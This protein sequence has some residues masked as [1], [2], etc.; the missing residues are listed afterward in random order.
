MPS[1]ICN[2]PT[3]YPPEIIGYAHPWIASGGDNVEIKVSSTQSPYKYRLL[4]LIQGL[5]VPHSPEVVLEHIPQA[6]E[7]T[8]AGRYQQSNPGSYGI[9]SNL[10]ITNQDQGLA[11]SLYVQPTLVLAGHTQTIVSLIDIGARSGITVLIGS[12]GRLKVRVGNGLNLLEFLIGHNIL[13][14]KQWL[15]LRLTVNQS[16]LRVFLQ[17]VHHLD[18]T[19]G[20]DYDETFDIQGFEIPKPG[21]AT[22]AASQPSSN[23]KACDFFNGRIEALHL[24]TLGESP[25]VILDLD[26]KLKISTDEIVDVSRYGNHGVLINAPTRAVTGHDWDGSETDWSKASNGYGAIHFHEDDL[27]DAAW[28]TDFVLQVPAG[29]RSGA[30]AVE[31]VQLA[32]ESVKDY[33]TFFVRPNYN[34]STAK[35]A[36]VL[37]TFTYTAYANERMY[38][39]TKSS[40]LAASGCFKPRE[41]DEDFRRMKRRNDL[42]LS[43]YDVHR[44]GSG[45]VFSST[46]RP[47]LNVRPGFHHWALDRPRE[48]SADLLMIGFLEKLK[49]PYDVTTDHDLH[50]YGI[51]ALSPYSTIIT[52]S[53]PEYPS[54]ECL[55]TYSAFAARG[56][57]IMYLGGNGFYWKSVPDPLHPHRLEVRRGDQGVRTFGLPGGER[58]HSLSGE[59]GGLWRSLGRAAN[60]LFGVGCCGE[61]VGPGVPY[62]R[63]TSS[64]DPR[65]TWVFQGLK[66]GELIGEHGFG[67]GASGDEIDRWDIKHGSPS[68]S[69]VL[70]SSTGHP[71]E[72]VLFP[73]DQ[74][75]Q[76]TN[77]TGTATDM[78]RSDIVLY[79]MASG[80]SVFSVGSMNWYNSLG[81]DGYD[82]SVAKVTENVI[83]RFLLTGSRL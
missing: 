47:I 44:D 79:E 83:R 24:A 56:G 80:G 54:I 16:N 46:K 48:F 67:G 42:G 82:N 11:L 17:P 57:N 31:V 60:Y 58:H 41:P 29:S 55:S 76:Q 43:L 1:T 70:A 37:S 4:R 23:A 81:W 66:E 9:I 53:H 50:S 28:E 32:D 10:G 59:R 33:I 6:S 18:Q 25:H 12:C 40:Y 30:Y 64:Q 15:G 49:I 71:D 19:Y 39:E 22:I 13:H 45:T 35:V 69:V 2:V 5:D 3:D 77:L 75:F 78:V 27:D 26:F 65:F 72:F 62:R 34:L 20:Y 38:D 74:G 36:L 73:E 7:G 8:I 51:H 52:G 68:T 61:G 21:R 14:E 63:T